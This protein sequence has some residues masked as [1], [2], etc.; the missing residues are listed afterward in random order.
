MA[1]ALRH[2]FMFI[3]EREADMTGVHSIIWRLGAVSIFSPRFIPFSFSL[4]HHSG[5]SSGQSYIF[6]A[7]F[8]FNISISTRRDLGEMTRMRSDCL[9]NT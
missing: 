2:F 7:A 5:W 9:H 6:W 4:S 8:L 3:S 1:A